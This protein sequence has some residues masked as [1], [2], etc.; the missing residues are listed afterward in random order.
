M[1]QS[2][3]TGSKS[4]SVD[5]ELEQIKSKCGWLFKTSKKHFEDFAGDQVTNSATKLFDFALRA[6]AEI[7]TSDDPFAKTIEV[8]GRKA[9][10]SSLARV[11][12]SQCL[13]VFGVA[14]YG[15]SP[16]VSFF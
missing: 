8:L 7:L 16:Q 15:I 2:K 13:G 6:G 3:D 9:V 11:L 5:Q 1:S 10:G 12:A 14:V 4:E